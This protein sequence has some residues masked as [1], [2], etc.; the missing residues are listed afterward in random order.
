MANGMKIIY[1]GPITPEGKPNTGGFESANRKNINALRRRGVDVDEY[2]YPVVPRKFGPAGKLVYARLLFTPFRWLR[3]R[4]R[5]DVVL[6]SAAPNGPF[7]MI[8]L[9]GQRM[10]RMLGI[11]TLTDMRAGT[12]PYLWATRGALFR[13]PLRSLLLHSDAVTAEG[14]GY[15]DFMRETVGLKKDAVY[16]PNTAEMSVEEAATKKKIPAADGK[17]N[18]FYFGRITRNKGIDVILEARKFLPSDYKIY[19]AGP[20]APDVDARAL[21]SEGTEY[22]GLLT[23]QELKE[24]MKRMHFFIFPTRHIG[25]GQSNSLIEAMS[26]GLVPVTSR[27]GF[28]SDVVADCGVTFPAEATGR[29]YAGAIMKIAAEDYA[30]RS[31][32]SRKHIAENHNIE[33]ETDKLIKIYAGLCG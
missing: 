18:V 13:R 11:K 7:T 6:H 28:C 16:F 8:T 10:A 9:W 29:D 14:R 26:N 15:I 4:G 31:E 5:K 30:E 17:I 25:E 12:L 27:Q 2:P 1:W 3:Y 24:E 22:L 20:I 33:K 21:D 23:P 32:R 19:L